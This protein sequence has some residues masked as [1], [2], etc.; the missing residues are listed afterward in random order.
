MCKANTR[1]F[2]FQTSGAKIFSE[3]AGHSEPLTDVDADLF[4]RQ[5]SAR[6]AE[7]VAD[8]VRD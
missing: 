7:G 5:C 6:G 8:L 3:F 1:T 4:E 2:H